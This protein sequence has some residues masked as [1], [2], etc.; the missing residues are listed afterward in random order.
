MSSLA[1]GIFAGW[2][3]P[4]DQVLVVD[5]PPASRDRD[6]TGRR[7]HQLTTRSSQQGPYSLRCLLAS[8]RPETLASH[9][10]SFLL[11]KLR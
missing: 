3:A 4:H 7:L 2:T 11:P 9:H 10:L 6:L 1:P 5:C 8:R